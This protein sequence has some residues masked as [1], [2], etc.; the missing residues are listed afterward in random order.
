MWRLSSGWWVT[1][2]G[3]RPGLHASVT[4]LDHAR[5]WPPEDEAVVPQWECTQA[6]GLC[7]CMPAERRRRR[8]D[9][10]PSIAHDVRRTR[11]PGCPN[12]RLPERGGMPRR[13]GPPHGGVTRHGRWHME[14]P[15][16]APSHAGKTTR[17]GPSHTEPQLHAPSLA[18][19][20]RH[21]LVHVD[22][23]DY[24]GS[25]LPLG[26]YACPRST[27]TI[28]KDPTDDPVM[29]PAAHVYAACSLSARPKTPRYPHQRSVLVSL[30][31]PVRW[32]LFNDE[33]CLRQYNF[34]DLVRP[35][36]WP[37][38]RASPAPASPGRLSVWPITYSNA[39]WRQYLRPPRA[40]DRK[41]RGVAVFISNCDPMT[42]TRRLD[43]LDALAASGVPVY[44]FGK[45]RNTH[46]VADV[47]PHCVGRQSTASGM[48]NFVK[49]CASR[50]FMFTAAFEND[51]A[52]DYV[53]E[54][55]FQPLVAGSVPIYAGAPNVRRYLPD[56]DAAV[57]VDLAAPDGGVAGMAE[58]VTGMLADTA[59]YRR[60][61]AWKARLASARR[62]VPPHL[63]DA[64]VT[65]SFGSLACLLC[66][67]VAGGMRMR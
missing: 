47:L 44:W 46:S 59:R 58:R 10:T 66:D 5:P 61:L 50:N 4:S 8:G 30:E 24:L 31:S 23:Y 35:G 67:E 40:V 54:K 51:V 22:P 32:P 17:Y 12:R 41:I 15:F 20:Q 1:R 34:T 53:T 38:P 43:L 7:D 37:V 18:A 64:Y 29:D 33:A 45:C 55:L 27:C 56:G 11:Q 14:T 42:A 13:G 36:L 28:V 2:Q 52:D 48:Y 62:R 25:E 60:A 39:D 63:Y 26:R 49:M 3:A 65:H 16:H 6:S 9:A 19:A 21:V 57:V